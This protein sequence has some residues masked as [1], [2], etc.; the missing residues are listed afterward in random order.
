[1]ILREKEKCVHNTYQKRT[2][3]CK[4]YVHVVLYCIKTRKLTVLLCVCER[5][6]M[7]E[8]GCVCTRVVAIT[9]RK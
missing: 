9:R 7:Y 6:Y 8:Y 4:Y 3:S 5:V 1:M 2:S